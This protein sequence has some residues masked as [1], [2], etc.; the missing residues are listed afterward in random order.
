MTFL[1]RLN[2]SLRLLT[3]VSALNRSL[4]KSISLLRSV[5]FIESE[6]FPAPIIGDDTQLVIAPVRLSIV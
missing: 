2:K 1:H 5:R 3:V 4:S 6:V